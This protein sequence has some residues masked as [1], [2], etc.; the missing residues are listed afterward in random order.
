MEKWLGR[1]VVDTAAQTV[2]GGEGLTATS[3]TMSPFSNTYLQASTS[4]TG[5]R[6]LLGCRCL[7]TLA[8]LAALAT[9]TALALAA[10][11]L[12]TLALAA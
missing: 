9:L 8:T 4:R 6:C 1:V 10:L 5:L 7:A 11:A 2:S 12:S 3:T